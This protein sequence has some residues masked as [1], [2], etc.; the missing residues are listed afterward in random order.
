MTLSDAVRAIEAA[1]FRSAGDLV[2][3]DYR[4]SSWS[5]GLFVTCFPGDKSDGDR[6]VLSFTV[7]ENGRVHKPDE[8]AASLAAAVERRKAMTGAGAIAA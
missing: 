2:S 3:L 7:D 1:G 4:L 5:G 8:F 6:Q